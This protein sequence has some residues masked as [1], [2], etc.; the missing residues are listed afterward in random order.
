[1]KLRIATQRFALCY[2]QQPASFLTLLLCVPHILSC[3]DGLCGNGVFLA[4]HV[5]ELLKLKEGSNIGPIV[6]QQVANV[7]TGDTTKVGRA[8]SGTVCSPVTITA[9]LGA[10][11]FRGWHACVARGCQRHW[12]DPAICSRVPT[13]QP[14]L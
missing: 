4:S 7:L 11:W 1:M 13:S 8:S 12:Q 5:A 10:G 6:R 3:A 9:L 14:Y 2:N